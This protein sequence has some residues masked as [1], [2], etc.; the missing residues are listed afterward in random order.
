MRDWL[1]ALR[2][3][4]QAGRASV[5]VTIADAKGSAPREAGVKMLVS[6]ERAVGTIGGGNLEYEAI[7]I[8]RRMLLERDQKS[9]IAQFA[10]GPSL[11]QCCG[12]NTKLLFEPF[13]GI[14]PAPAWIEKLLEILDQTRPSVLVSDIEGSGADKLLVASAEIIGK[15]VV[16]TAGDPALVE[17]ELV[18][19]ALVEK[20]RA[21]L[22]HPA[23]SAARFWTSEA[24][25]VFLLERNAA[26]QGDVLLI[27]AGHVGKA[28][29]PVLATLPLRVTWADNRP[30][31]FPDELP[32]GIRI[33]CTPHL[34]SAI[35]EAAP[36]T[37]FLVM[38]YSHDLDYALCA[39]I[40]QRGDFRYLGL[41]GSRTKRQRFEKTM[42]DLG[43]AQDVIDR[44]VCPI[45][46]PGVASKQPS[47]IAV[48][49]AA[50]I[51][52][53]P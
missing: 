2:D 50:Q 41:I 5:L 20:A 19:P 23:D 48:A 16:G 8:A 49:T 45:G 35:N 21:M 24:G 30:E 33:R 47:V 32:P 29:I 6:E 52:A 15:E 12:G 36:G 43:L 9:H 7:K 53:L 10:L 42:R 37:I 26:S 28:L 17:P 34:E 1:T 51:L 3:C 11:G 27:G 13:D 39:R 14:P 18:E 31:Q 40:L 4:I 46:I 25:R 22:A 44:V 38:T